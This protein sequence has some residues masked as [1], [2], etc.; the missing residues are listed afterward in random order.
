MHH[1][2][3]WD[4]TNVYPSLESP[5]FDAAV[6]AVQQQI[7]AHKAVV[8]DVAFSPRGDILASCSTDGRVC[9]SDLQ[10]GKLLHNLEAGAPPMRHLKFSPDG[11]LLVGSGDDGS[12]RLWQTAT[13]ALLHQLRVPA[14]GIVQAVFSADGRSLAA[15]SYGQILLWDAVSG[16]RLALLERTRQGVYGLAFSPDGSLLAVGGNSHVSLWDIAAGEELAV[17]LGHR[18]G[19]WKVAFSPDGQTLATLA[20]GQTVRLWHV[21][22]RRELF[23]LLRSDR[24]LNWLQFTSPHTLLVGMAPDEQ[25]VSEVAVFAGNA[26]TEADGSRMGPTSRSSQAEPA[27]SPRY[28]DDL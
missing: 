19:V 26:I 23:T 21:P 25:G 5:E 7:A 24:P 3:H 9:L 15:G 10:T 18:G 27:D 12:V 22:T 6:V 13:G 20:S 28:V 8:H 16:N 17:M 2:P 11:D 4:L 1:L 14:G